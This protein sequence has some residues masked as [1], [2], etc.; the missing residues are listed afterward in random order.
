[1]YEFFF[2]AR[3]MGIGDHLNGERECRICLCSKRY[4]LYILKVPCVPK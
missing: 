4:S 1:M 3:L 2:I